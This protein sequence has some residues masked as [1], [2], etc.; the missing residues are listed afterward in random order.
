MPTLKRFVSRKRLVTAPLS[1]Y[2]SRIRIREIY[3]EYFQTLKTFR[4]IKSNYSSTEYKTNVCSKCCFA[5]CCASS[6]NCPAMATG[7][8]NEDLT[9]R[10]NF[11]R[12]TVQ[13]IVEGRQPF[14]FIVKVH[15]YKLDGYINRFDE[16]RQ[17]Y[18]ET[19]LTFT[20]NPYAYLTNYKHISYQINH[21]VFQNTNV[22]DSIDY[23]MYFYV[24]KRL[25]LGE[26]AN[27]GIM[28]SNRLAVVNCVGCEMYNVNS[29]I[30]K[31][32]KLSVDPTLR[33]YQNSD[34]E[35][36]LDTVPPINIWNYKD[37]TDI[38]LDGSPLY[39]VIEPVSGHE[40]QTNARS[41]SVQQTVQYAL[42]LKKQPQYHAF[43]ILG[44]KS[45]YV[46]T[47]FPANSIL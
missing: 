8:S 25:I 33:P 31:M 36:S 39:V 18:P 34:I 3:P 4:I 16:P 23:H 46:R 44:T 14:A 30:C 19:F 5:N 45:F 40:R 27:F 2:R 12:V 1:S 24:Y 21:N 13:D 42:Y 37:Y 47:A 35:Q 41:V 6:A 10:L 43:K 11:E 17:I 22:I 15:K 20:S 29:P 32:C 28:E 26:L 9:K 7:E 38:K